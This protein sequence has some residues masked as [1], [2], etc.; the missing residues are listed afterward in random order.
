M[1]LASNAASNFMFSSGF[2]VS[3]SLLRCMFLNVIFVEFCDGPD[4][5]L[6]DFDALRMPMLLA[7][8]W[9]WMKNSNFFYVLCNVLSVRRLCLNV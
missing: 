1:I 5:K 3:C 2:C 9:F 4:R 6:F 7:E 8:A